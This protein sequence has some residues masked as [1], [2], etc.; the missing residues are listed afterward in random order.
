MNFGVKLKPN[1][2]AGGCKQKAKDEM[3][4]VLGKYDARCRQRC[5]FNKTVRSVFVSCDRHRY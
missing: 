1:I 5:P 2:S 3:C 4:G